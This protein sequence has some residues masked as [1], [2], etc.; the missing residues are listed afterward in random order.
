MEDP[1]LFGA[2]FAGD[3]WTAWR[4]FLRALFRLPME[5]EDLEVYTRF[6]VPLGKPRVPAIV[7]K[8]DQKS[9]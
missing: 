6:T 4:V 1:K 9:C 3:S 8:T 7:V 2:W 5:G